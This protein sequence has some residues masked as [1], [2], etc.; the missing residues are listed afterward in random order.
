MKEKYGSE[1]IGFVLTMEDQYLKE[2]NIAGDTPK[3]SAPLVLNYL[4]VEQYVIE[5]AK[6]EEFEVTLDEVR[7]IFAGEEKYMKRIGLIKDYGPVNN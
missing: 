4:K 7:T 5:K 3:E 1:E 2:V 6:E